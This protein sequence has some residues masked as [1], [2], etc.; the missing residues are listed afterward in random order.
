[1]RASTIFALSVAILLGLGVAVAAKLT[2]YFTQ[3]TVAAEK[4]ADIQ[5]L[6]NRNGRP[7]RGRISICV[8]SI[9]RY[10][11]AIVTRPVLRISRGGHRHG[12]GICL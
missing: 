5:V 11:Q 4:K 2:G 12:S 10:R 9:L 6:G 7:I 8:L 3:P 1:M